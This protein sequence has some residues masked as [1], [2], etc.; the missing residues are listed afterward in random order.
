MMMIKACAIRLWAPAIVI[1][2]VLAVSS[3]LLEAQAAPAPAQASPSIV[4]SLLD[5]AHALDVRGRI[6]L[7][8]QT[9]QQVLLTDPRNTEALAGLA[10][11]AKL[12]NSPVLAKSYLER[13]R[14]INP[15]DPNIALIESMGTK[16]DQQSQLQQAAKLAEAGKYDAAMIVYRRV[17]GP[18][19]P[20]GDW[21]LA[22]YETEAATED[23]RAHAVAGLRA[24]LDKDPGNVQ[25]RIGLGRVLTYDPATREEGR[26]YLASFPNDPKAAEAFRQSLLWDVANAAV[27]PQIRAYL[28]A[29]PDPQLAA[30]LQSGQQPAAKGPT[31]HTP[32]PTPVAPIPA[33]VS[34]PKAVTAPAMAAPKAPPAAAPAPAPARA[35]SPAE[36]T[37]G[38]ARARSA[39][40]AAYEALNA[41]HLDEAEAR[42]KALLAAD[43]RDPTALA[44]IGY[45]RMQQGN[46]AGAIGFLEQAK[47]YNDK[48]KGLASALD[49]A[50]FWFVMG[51][52]QRALNA[53]D[54]T[55]A[56]KLY[57]AALELRPNSI[58]ALEGL[59]GT[60]IKARQPGPAIPLF[61]RAVAAD[62]ASVPGWRGLFIA[63]T[64]SGN[65]PLA[66]VTDKQIPA[67]VH[68]QLMSD[69]L[70]L[71]SL[72]AAYSAVGQPGDA[73]KTL[74]TAIELPNPAGA[75]GAKSDTQL[76]L[77]EL[78]ASSNHLDQAE[79]LY[80]QAAADDHESAAA[81][82]GLVRVQHALGHDPDA[83]KSVESMPPATY[84]EAMRDPAFVIVVASVYEA[85]KKF[86]EAQ[87]L[88][89]KA[90]SQQTDAGQKP[91]PALLM[92]LA[93]L[94]GQRGAPQLASPFY[95]Q[96]IRD[97]P[98]RTDA[99]AGLVSALHA[100]AHDKEAADQIK[101]VPPQVRAQ[102]E[103]NDAY[104]ETMASV[105]QALGR[106]REAAPYLN[107]I[108]QDYAMQSKAPPADVEIQ[109]AWALYNGMEDA[110]LY[111][112]LIDL[113]SR[114]GLTP[115]QRKT[116][117]TI[118]TN[119]AVRRA[120]QAAAAGN[121]GRALAI[122]DAAALAFPDNPATVKALAIGY[123]A[124]GRSHQSVLIYK[125]QNMS[126]ASSADYQAAVAAALADGDSKDA[127]IWLRYALA[128]Y[129]SDPQ[130]LMLGARFEQVRG[131]TARAI[132]YY[133]ESL[134]AMPPAP[135]SKLTPELGLPAPSPP[136]SL[137][138]ANRLQGLSILLAPDTGDL[139]SPAPVIPAVPYP[140]YSKPL[141]P[142]DPMSGVVPTYM[143]NPGKPTGS[144]SP[145]RPAAGAANP[146]S[147]PEV[148]AAV[149]H[150]TAQALGHAQP[151][152][153][154][155]ISDAFTPQ[156]YQAQ[157]VAQLTQQAAAQP[158]P[159][160]SAVPSQEA[161][162]PA[163][164]YIAPPS[165]AATPAVAD[166][167]VTGR[168]VLPVQLGNT[169]P[170][171]V[172]PQ[173]D[174]TDVLPTSR[175]A[176]SARANEAARAEPEVAAAR[177]ARVRQL[178]EDAA[179]RTGVSHPPGDGAVTAI[180]LNA[181][182]TPAQSTQN[183][184]A[185]QIP[186]PATGPAGQ[187]SNIPNTG[188]QQY[189]QP[190][191]PPPAVKPP[192]AAHGR[193]VAPAPAPPIPVA[194]VPVVVAP[195]PAPPQPA[196]SVPATPAPNLAP[197]YPPIAP[198]YPLAPPPT[199]AELRALNLPPLRGFFGSQAPIPMTP[200]QQAESELASLEGSY[201]G[202][203]GATGSGRYRGGTPGLDRLYDI[204]SPLEASAV[205]GRSARITAVALPVFLNSGL[206]NPSSFTTS[207]VPY[208]GTLP[209]N[210][211]TAPAQQ[212]SNGVGG[213]LQ[214]T[215]KN[216]GLAAGYTPYS[217]LVRNLTGRFLFTTLGGHLSLFGTRD[218]VKDT[219]LSYAGLHDPGPAPPGP[220]WG[221]VVSTTGG[222]RL[223]LGNSRANFFLSGSGGELT[224]RHVLANTM[225]QGTTGANFR[226]GSWPS[227][228]S[229]TLGYVLAG[230]HYQHDEVGLSYGQGG[231]FSPGTYF[232]AAVP[233]AFNGRFK[234]NFHY[235]IAGALGV[236]TFEQEEAPFY[237]LDP[238]LQSSF[239]PSN[240]I[241]CTA[242]QIPS[243][244]CGEY[245][246][247]DSTIFNYAVNAEASYRFAGHWYGGGYLSANNTS[248]YSTVSA[249]FFFRYVFSPQHSAE[250]YPPGLFRVQGLR[251]LQI[252]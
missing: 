100:A 33:Q 110:G 89:Q 19:P 172:Q 141:S 3:V 248:N 102:L 165:V 183:Q 22:Y 95:Q 218:P 147:P 13:L 234:A 49:T 107:R 142:Y 189:P 239:V 66:L 129:P 11:S 50:R 43:P 131:D 106:S 198:A 112:Q 1:G 225:F 208:L 164:A 35:P 247:Q 93:D 52:G 252:P 6:D 103:T 96:V 109:N 78:L 170:P 2:S 57:R 118:W 91:S 128:A 72:A 223:T 125:A 144:Q 25:Y 205:I 193:T 70:F 229:L 174:I 10:R 29:H 83:L 228:G 185:S 51:E 30:A 59:G 232:L 241:P 9:W 179:A 214:L 75:R 137:P 220:I 79:P 243:Y 47:Q 113:G 120:N 37:D 251:P 7:A 132:K 245:P 82:Q 65:A 31:F 219:Q 81:W 126:S 199:D 159:A 127:E 86:D 38:A 197:A 34:T 36:S 40:M 180:T 195:A 213:E 150:A 188:A 175:Y 4:R 92:Q 111:R 155:P 149:Q 231:Y 64:Q 55:T 119:W 154:A 14:A 60:L 104:L 42:F 201:S 200:R 123:A 5:K 69:P 210:A 146:P 192:A 138:N 84:A 99:W 16:Q 166:K 68:T 53:N 244:N 108:E 171:P 122:L 191:T 206:L 15:N 27:A 187:F 169:T 58:D 87:Q 135:V 209:A 28:A 196:P 46:F 161:S 90:V 242:A 26:E 194:A 136:G 39:E 190:R 77:A 54:L 202:W 227:Y 24:L 105:Y 212:Y 32:A 162:G 130:I 177:A 167:G 73:Q 8:E 157:Q 222:V 160:P 152:P 158:P 207:Y 237:P 139:P 85:G 74:E 133:R 204:E 224:G 182:Y 184:G 226:I 20:P 114:T 45:V 156:A 101:T 217:F 41:N 116:L 115:D 17:F 181:E 56:E 44:G 235:A 140:A 62:P 178:Q 153:G 163:V 71:T 98:G 148:A 249:G 23:G 230:M 186:Q 97:D 176:P 211:T 250:G 67:S 80:A 221:G 76:R 240:G 173:T 63:Q 145:P 61:Q 18:A 134:K 88:L 246:R 236:Q 12:N 215:T 203:L 124:A 117:E 21:A 151:T 143:S 238:A 121:T 48:D 168:T 233:I 94:Y 216:L